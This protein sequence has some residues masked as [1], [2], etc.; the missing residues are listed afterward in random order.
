MAGASGE[1]A[2]QQD[3]PK[4]VDNIDPNFSSHSPECLRARFPN[5]DHYQPRAAGFCLMMSAVFMIIAAAIVLAVVV[6]VYLVPGFRIIP[7]GWCPLL[8][9]PQS[10]LQWRV[11][12][13]TV[14]LGDLTAVGSAV[15][16]ILCPVESP[17]PLSRKLS[18]QNLS[19]TPPFKIDYPYPV[20]V[21]AHHSWIVALSRHHAG[22]L[23]CIRSNRGFAVR[24]VLGA[25]VR[26]AT[27][28]CC[29][30]DD[31]LLHRL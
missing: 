28:A 11:F 4:K 10:R 6:D 14:A 3:Q 23:H 22:C 31:A 29:R 13:R 2:P 27:C 19:S 26:V 8:R 7:I 9:R 5:Y 24:P 25:R 15:L 20:V 17:S 18:V 1:A 16:C 21:P 30:R 12:R